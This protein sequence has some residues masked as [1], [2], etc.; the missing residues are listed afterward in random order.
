MYACQDLKDDVQAGVKS[1]TILFG[2]YIREILFFFAGVVVV[3]LGLAGYSNEQ[4]PLYYILCVAGTATHMGWQLR[5]VDFDSPKDCF[6]VSKVRA[7][8]FQPEHA[9]TRDFRS[10][11]ATSVCSYGQA[12]SV[13]TSG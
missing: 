6:L 3:T 12:C 4:G 13:I 8:H 7:E 10:P 11:S 9:L 1:T 2:S 5:T